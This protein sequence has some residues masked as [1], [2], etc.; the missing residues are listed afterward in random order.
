MIS[1][2]RNIADVSD[3]KALVNEAIALK[4]DPYAFK[5]L[6][7][8]KS[9]GVIFLN[10]SLRTRMSTQK[11]A[12]NLGMDFVLMNMTGEG[13][14]LETKKGVVMDGNTQ[15]HVIEAAAVLGQYF[16]VLALRS[17]PLLKSREEDAQESILSAF[18]EHSGIPVINMESATAHPL[19]G[20]ADAMTVTEL[21]KKAK[22]KVVLS[23]APHPRAL[24][25]AVPN[26]FV[27]WMKELD[28]VELVVT[29]PEGYELEEKIIGDV[30]VEYDQDKALQGADFVYAKNW[31]S[32]SSYGQI[33]SKDNTWMIDNKKMG[34]TDQGLFMHCLPVRRNV[35]VA[36]EVLDGS[37]SCVTQQA[38]NRLW[39]AQAVLKQMLESNL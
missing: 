12:V 13:Y 39:A 33:L 22:K 31:S 28:D 30:Q 9:I 20:L 18:V 16:D 11:A 15:E 36:D 26:S 24:P 29:H 10:P 35:I 19:Q 37:Q 23:W 27:S 7:E 17:F 3:V 34:L 32:V 8:N 6:G 5:K 4:S 38:G 14:A 25:Q 21:S 2:F 1:H